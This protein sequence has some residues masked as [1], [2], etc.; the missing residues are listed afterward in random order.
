MQARGAAL[1]VE[2]ALSWLAAKPEIVD[3]PERAAVPAGIRI[4]EESRSEITRYVLVYMPLAA[5]LL[6]IAVA[7]RRRSTEGAPRAR[8]PSKNAPRDPRRGKKT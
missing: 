6:G 1:L 3:I 2:S 5:G 8:A 7:L 4:T